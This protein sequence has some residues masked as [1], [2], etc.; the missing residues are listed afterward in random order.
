MFYFSWNLQE[1]R[2][3]TFKLQKMIEEF[4]DAN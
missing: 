4:V 3:Q 1:T 2:I